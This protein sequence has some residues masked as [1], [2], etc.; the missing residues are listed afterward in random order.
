MEHRIDAAVVEDEQEVEVGEVVGLRTVKE[1]G[2]LQMERMME[3]PEDLPIEAAV[4]DH[5]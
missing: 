2:E 1:D 3:E 4:D 5:L